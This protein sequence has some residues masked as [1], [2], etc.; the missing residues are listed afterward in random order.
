MRAIKT[1]GD[2]RGFLADVL[3]GVK[4][5]T[6]DASKAGAIS[7]VAAQINVSLATE[8]QARIHLKELDSD[9]AGSMV[10]A[11]S[12]VEG[13]APR[14]LTQ[15]APAQSQQAP[16]VREAPVPV[17]AASAVTMEDATANFRRNKMANDQI[18]CEQCELRVTVEQAVGCKSRYCKAKEAA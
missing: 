6:I 8:V 11:G 3:M 5:G 15:D 4:D 9:T 1:A 12:A 16:M 10:I 7:K 2:L 14:E 17:E 13:E 18:W